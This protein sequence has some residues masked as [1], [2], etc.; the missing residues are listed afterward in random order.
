MIN[1]IAIA[2][3]LAL[4]FGGLA[5]AFIGGDFA[6]RQASRGGRENR[7]EGECGGWR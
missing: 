6:S 7:P 3:A 4:G 2:A 5:F 1:P